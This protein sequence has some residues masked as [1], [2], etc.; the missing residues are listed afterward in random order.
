MNV[1][2]LYKLPSRWGTSKVLCSKI[3]F[4]MKRNLIIVLLIFSS[5]SAVALNALA[6]PINLLLREA[7]LAASLEEI[8]KQSGYLIWYE[9]G[10]LD[11]AKLVTLSARNTELE[12]ALNQVFAAQPVTYEIVGKTIVVK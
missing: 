11:N 2:S 4:Y 9:D 3:Q 6:Q 12:D 7:T 1:V 10:I 5:S 8:K